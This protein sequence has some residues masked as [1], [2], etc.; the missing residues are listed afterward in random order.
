MESGLS[1]RPALVVR[2]DVCG[3]DGVQAPS[4]KEYVEQDEANMV[5]GVEPFTMDYTPH[6]RRHGSSGRGGSKKEYEQVFLQGVNQATA[7]GDAMELTT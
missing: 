3:S 1:A 2:V 4:D 5:S 7:A 6:W